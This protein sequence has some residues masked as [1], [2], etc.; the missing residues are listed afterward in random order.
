MKEQNVIQD[1][2]IGI[3]LSQYQPVQINSSRVHKGS[4]LLF[5]NKD[6]HWLDFTG[7]TL[8][9]PKKRCHMLLLPGQCVA[10]DSTKMIPM[11][12]LGCACS[13]LVQKANRVR[14]SLLFHWDESHITFCMPIFCT[15]F[16]LWQTNVTK[17]Q[18]DY[19]IS[20]WCPLLK[21]LLNSSVEEYD[22]R[23]HKLCL[24]KRSIMRVNLVRGH[25][26]TTLSP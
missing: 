16:S 9:S 6:Q 24:L 11:A 18:G 21:P 23:L 17:T 25:N 19:C 14:S 13:E 2:N 5:F 15:I 4:V 12:V 8:D 22:I 10:L 1:T 7:K 3:C 20:V 26:N